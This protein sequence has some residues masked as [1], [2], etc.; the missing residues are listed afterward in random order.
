ML[1][2]VHV[3]MIAH[4]V[5]WLAHGTTLSPIEPSEGMELAKHD[6]VNAGLVF[7]VAA[8]FAT[9]VFGRFFCGWGCHLV[10]LQDLSRWL[11]IKV[12]IRPRAVRS[13]WLGIVP[14]TAFGY[15]FLWPAIYRIAVGDRFGP[16]RA[17]FLTTDFW[18]TFPGLAVAVAT[19][20]V[21]GFGAVLVLGAKGFCTYA[22]PYG[23]AFALADRLAPIR[24]RV[25]DGHFGIRVG[26]PYA[27]GYT[28]NIDRVV[29]GTAA[30]TTVFDFEPAIG[31]PGDKDACKKGGWQQFNAPAFRNQGDCVSFVASG[32]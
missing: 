20:V 19:F 11:L 14:L 4:V 27:S 23:A 8:V 18:A 30:G 16:L 7:F 31:P 28:E 25:T 3:V 26:S 1:A 32:K 9:A 29:F 17:E 15:M 12:G 24:I 6:V 22:C 13:R 10:A 2:A 21:C 5:Q